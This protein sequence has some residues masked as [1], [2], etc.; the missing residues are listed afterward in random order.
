[1]GITS[2]LATAGGW[3]HGNVFQ[4]D[5]SM[6][7]LHADDTVVS[8]RVH[9]DV[10]NVDF[11]TAMLLANRVTNTFYSALDDQHVLI[12]AD[13]TANHAQY[14]RMG[15]RTFFLPDFSA[16]GSDFNDIVNTLRTL[17]ELRFIG[18]QP[19]SGT[20]AVRGPQPIVEAA[21]QW[22]QNIDTARSG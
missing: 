4:I 2:A 10:D 14:D 15:L 22:L 21:T 3:G 18:T 17:F 20:I 13:S 1:M 8:R 6:V 5:F 7:I 12:A 19:Q 16:S 11:D 9:F